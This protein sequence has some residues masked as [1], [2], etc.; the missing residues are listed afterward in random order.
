M[1]QIPYQPMRGPQK[2]V[3]QLEMWETLK[4]HLPPG[5][6]FKVVVQ[7]DQTPKAEPAVAL[8]PLEWGEFVRTGKTSGYALTLCGRFSIEVRRV[9]GAWMYMAWL[10]KEPPHD[11]VTLGIRTTRAEAETLCRKEAEKL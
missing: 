2:E 4:R 11:S 1:T 7:V 3:S 9:H 10:R 8:Q 5:S 6:S